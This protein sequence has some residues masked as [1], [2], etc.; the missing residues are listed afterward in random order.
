MSDLKEE[1]LSVK[2]EIAGIVFFLA[3]YAILSSFLEYRKLP[4]HRGAVAVI[5][6]VV[7]GLVMVLSSRETYEKVVSH[8]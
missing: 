3:S 5:I 6:G 4:I 2:L 8:I 7:A 1:S